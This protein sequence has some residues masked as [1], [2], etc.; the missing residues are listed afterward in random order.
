[1]DLELKGKSVLITGA[2]KG[3]GK[4]CAIAF[5]KEE[6]ATI[7]AVA[8]SKDELEDLSKNIQESYDVDVKIH[9]LDVTDKVLRNNLITNTRDIDILINNAGAIPSGSIYAVSE[10]AWRKGWELKVFGYIEMTRAY[11][12][13]FRERGFG[14]IL[15]DIGN[16]GENPDFDYVA[17]STGNSALMTFTKAIGGTSLDYGVRV[18]AVNPGPV[19]TGR[20]EKMLRQR[21]GVILNDEGRWE[22]LLGRFPGGRASTPEEIANAIAFLSS[23][24]ASYINGCVVTIDG[25]IS[26][27]GSVV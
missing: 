15:N 8:R 26:A 20:M 22:E 2:S 1:M 24:A 27:R 23:P 12:T 11:Y 19:D 4:A 14:V 13:I 9:P 5:A 21:A 16:S 25:G 7:H 18:L 17:G 6:V 10:E 3:I